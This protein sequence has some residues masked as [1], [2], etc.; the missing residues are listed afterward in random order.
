MRVKSSAIAAAC[1]ATAA[2][3]GSLAGCS[4]PNDPRINPK[5]RYSLEMQVVGELNAGGHAVSKDDY[6]I[7]QYEWRNPKTRRREVLMLFEKKPPT[8]APSGFVYAYDLDLDRRCGLRSSITSVED[9]WSPPR[10]AATAITSE[11]AK[12]ASLP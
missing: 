10:G 1:I 7:F 4:N 5:M 6:R 12:N 8:N 11:P 9:S 3:L 2:S